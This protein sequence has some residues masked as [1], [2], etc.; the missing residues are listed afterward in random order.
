MVGVCGAPTLGM[1]TR[2]S[3][4]FMLRGCTLSK[5]QRTLKTNCGRRCRRHFDLPCAFFDP[6][7]PFPFPSSARHSPLSSCNSLCNC[8]C[9]LRGSKKLFSSHA[10]ALPLPLLVVFCSCK[11]LSPFSLPPPS[12]RRSLRLFG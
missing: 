8:R 1:H 7:H 10:H 12:L 3:T 4:L 6:L 2:V 9:T 11:H 5:R